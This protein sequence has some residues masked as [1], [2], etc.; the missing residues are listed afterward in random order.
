[1]QHIYTK[2][3]ATGRTQFVGTANIALKLI[4]TA[5]T[6]TPTPTPRATPTATIYVSFKLVRR[7]RKKIKTYI[8]K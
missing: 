5:T 2:A 6:A 7:K 3:A 4:T 8:N 1:M